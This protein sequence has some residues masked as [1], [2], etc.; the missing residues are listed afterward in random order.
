VIDFEARLLLGL[1]GLCVEQVFVDR[2]EALKAGV[3]I[4][5]A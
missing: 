1:G 2:G 5:L 4:F 3:L